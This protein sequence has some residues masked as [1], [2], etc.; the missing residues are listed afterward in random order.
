M[1]GAIEIAKKHC[2]AGILRAKHRPR[3]RHVPYHRALPVLLAVTLTASRTFGQTIDRH[4]AILV[5]VSSSIGKGGPNSELFRDYLVAVKKLLLSEPPQSRVWVSTITT[6]SFGSARSIL[7]GWTPEVRGIFD[8]DLNRAR[9]EFAAS[10]ESKST[11][12]RPTAAGTDIIGGFWQA[13][14]LLESGAKGAEVP[15]T[16]WIL[17]DVMNE[18]ASFNMPALLPAGP[19]EMLER[20]KVNGLIVPLH[21]LSDT[22]DWSVPCGAY[23]PGLEYPEG[24]LGPLFP[25]NW[26]CPHLLLR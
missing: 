26:S 19:G 11:G 12:L 21:G 8:D 14:A 4:E 17:S 13:K 16:I 10:F 23:A 1:L 7:K 25:R 18:S 2:M 24:I 6:D 9:H 22:R 3:K 15:K 20:A 5:D